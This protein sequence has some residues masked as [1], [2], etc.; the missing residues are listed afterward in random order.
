MKIA[1][2]VCVI[3]AVADTLML[4]CLA[5]VGGKDDERNGRK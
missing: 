3:C 5:R 1:I 2:A 4:Y